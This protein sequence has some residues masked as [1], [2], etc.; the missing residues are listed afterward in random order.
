MK[1][2][3]WGAWLPLGLAVAMLISL[4][5]LS[6]TGTV[7]RVG[8]WSVR[9]RPVQEWFRWGVRGTVFVQKKPDGTYGPLSEHRYHG[10][11]ERSRRVPGPEARRLIAFLEQQN[12]K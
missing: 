2:S 3:K 4:L 10:I 6:L 1:M 12:R 11:F 8:E 5:L 7:Q 9:V